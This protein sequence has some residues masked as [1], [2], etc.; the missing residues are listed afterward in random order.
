MNSAK[1]TGLKKKKKNAPNA[2][3]PRR[4]RKSKLTLSMVT[5]PKN[6]SKQTT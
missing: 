2:K 6:N 4:G 5:L 1:H 3:R